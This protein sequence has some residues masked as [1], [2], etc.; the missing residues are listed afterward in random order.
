MWG[1]AG[2]EILFSRI[3]DVVV[4]GSEVRKVKLPNDYQRLTIGAGDDLQFVHDASHSYIEGYTGNLYIR[5]Y[6]RNTLIISKLLYMAKIK[7]FLI[8]N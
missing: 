5:N 8:K 4:V 1:D 2:Q 7:I 3:E 6:Q